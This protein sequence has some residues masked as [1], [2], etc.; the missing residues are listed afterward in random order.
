MSP[1]TSLPWFICRSGLYTGGSGTNTL[2]FTY[3]VTDGTVTQ[4]ATLTLN[5][6]P[7]G[8][9]DDVAAGRATALTDP[10]YNK[11]FAEMYAA[12]DGARRISTSAG[13]PDGFCGVTTSLG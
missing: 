10:T 7:L 9:V 11:M 2:T 5:V 8:A 4:T 3:T 12:T 13:R 6:I 1:C